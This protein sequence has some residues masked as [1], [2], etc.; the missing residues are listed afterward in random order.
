MK[1]KSG[2]RYTS[3]LIQFRKF[4]NNVKLSV[5]FTRRILNLAIITRH[6]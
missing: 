5:K 6:V 1:K 2:L 4:T 3:G